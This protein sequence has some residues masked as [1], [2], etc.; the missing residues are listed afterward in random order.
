M[1]SKTISQLIHWAGILIL[2]F[3]ITRTGTPAE[4]SLAWD[5]SI[6]ENIAGYKVYVGTATRTYTAPITVGNQTTYTVEG[7]K[8]GTF[9]FAVTAFN[10]AGDESDFSNEV[11]TTIA[12]GAPSPPP[13]HIPTIPTIGPVIS[14]QAVV[15]IGLNSATIA[16]QT[17]EECSGSLYFGIDEVNLQGKISNNQGTTAHL[18]NIT[19]L[20]RR[21]RYVY[22]LRGVCGTTIVQS[23]FFSFNTKN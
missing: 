16:W 11:N 21:T 19:A 10:A 23:S 14:W 8:P 18:V 6:S 1:A 22:Q 9:Y 17:S 12:G 13:L 4:V 7:L 5:A 15:A 20:T 3:F 2:I